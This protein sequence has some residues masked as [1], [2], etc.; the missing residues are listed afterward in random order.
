MVRPTILSTSVCLSSQIFW[1]KLLRLCLY[2]YKFKYN[3]LNYSSSCGEWLFTGSFETCDLNFCLEINP[4]VQWTNMFVSTWREC[5]GWHHRLNLATN[6]AGLNFYR[7]VS[8]LHDEARDVE[9]TCQFLS[10][11]VVLRRQRKSSQ[12]VHRNIQEVWEQFS[13]GDITAKDVLRRFVASLL[14]FS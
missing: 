2:W 8:L 4:S 12:K 14:V 9:H 5:E 1:I 13:A 3:F 11:D 7:L 10:N 6:H